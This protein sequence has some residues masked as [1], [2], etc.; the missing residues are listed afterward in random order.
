MIKG[1]IQRENCFTFLRYLF[2]FCIFCNHLCFTTGNERFLCN[3]IIFVNGF[4][5]ISGFLTFNSFVKNPDIKT[6]ALKRI[7]R[8]LP[9]YFIAVVL[10]FFIGM[11]LTSLDFSDFISRAE[12]WKYLGAN[13]LFLNHFQPTLPGVFENNAMPFINSSLWTMK[14]E[15]AFYI[16]V[17]VVYA[18]M[19]KFGKNKVLV[20]I[21]LFS[22]LYS[23]VTKEL[24]EHTHKEIYNI[25]NHQIPGE[26]SFFYAPVL[27]LLNLEKVERMYKWL[28]PFSVVLFLVSFP[29]YKMYY[30]S[31]L[32]LTVLIIFFAYKAEPYIKAYRW[33][34][35]SYE[36][37]LL[38]FP[39]LQIVVYAGFT[40]SLLLIAIV[41]LTVTILAAV[42]LHMVCRRISKVL[43][44]RQA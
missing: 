22:V 11:A 39:V 23:I 43:P 32:Y 2:A 15:I 41:A 34:D 17:P 21:V 38:R 44:P 9:A 13:M 25:L 40:N 24:Y 18:L 5:I 19:R 6:F 12:T 20:M 37:Y 30:I 14:I 35:I 31:P 27:M 4:F 7:R 33:R 36:F 8:I 3:G 10:G 42:A 29:L 16:S 28:V 26:L 1:Y